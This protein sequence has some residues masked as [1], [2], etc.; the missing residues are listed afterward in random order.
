[1]SV[2]SSRTGGSRS[3]SYDPGE[4]LA[5]SQPAL[6]IELSSAHWAIFRG[7]NT[8]GRGGVTHIDQ[9]GLCLVLEPR[10]GCTSTRAWGHGLSQDT[11]LLTRAGTWSLQPN[12]PP[13]TSSDVPHGNQDI[14]WTPVHKKIPGLK[15]VC[16]LSEGGKDTPKPHREP[17][18]HQS[19]PPHGSSRGNTRK[20]T[21]TQA[22]MGQYISRLSEAMKRWMAKPRF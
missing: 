9:P 20:V 7:G 21:S 5:T 12:K 4:G 13:H 16:L 19:T 3:G 22:R 18:G 17:S 8:M 6:K 15:P 1:M 2:P 14:E 10:G 11:L